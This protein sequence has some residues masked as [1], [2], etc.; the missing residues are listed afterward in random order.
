MKKTIWSAVLAMALLLVFVALGLSIES[1]ATRTVTGSVIGVDSGGKGLA[2]STGEG[3]QAMVAGAIVNDSTD[4]RIKG[5][6]ADLTQIKTGDK[7]TMTYAYQ[8]N[9]LYAK[10]ITKK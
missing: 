6:K 3:G 5:K 7:V 2:V 8:D 4:I 1:G 9:D 10:K